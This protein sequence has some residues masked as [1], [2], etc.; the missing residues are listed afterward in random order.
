MRTEDSMM[1]DGHTMPLFS[2]YILLGAVLPLV[3]C[4]LR[5]QALPS[6]HLNPIDVDGRADIGS[7]LDVLR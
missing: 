1:V 4:H 6:K 7:R 2:P 5:S 3:S